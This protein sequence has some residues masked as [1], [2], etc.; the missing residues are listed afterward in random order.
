MDAA[1]YSRLANH[2]VK[3][4]GEALASAK[5]GDLEDAEFSLALAREIGLDKDGNARAR[6]ASVVRE[7]ERF[8]KYREFMRHMKEVDN[9]IRAGNL[10]GAMKKLNQAVPLAT[11]DAMAD[12]AN[13]RCTQIQ[14][15]RQATAA[16]EVRAK[17]EAEAKARAEAEAKAAKG[18]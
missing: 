2:H 15:I 4:T 18:D 12:E 1:T 7:M 6:E 5:A 14:Q 3:L 8:K 9:L 11:D 10:D 17:A 13:K 16:I